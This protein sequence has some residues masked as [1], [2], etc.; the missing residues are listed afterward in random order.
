MDD[1]QETIHQIRA[2]NRFYTVLLGFLNQDYFGS[3]YSVTQTRILFELQQNGQMSASQL[4]DLLHLD[5][6][7]VSRLIRSLEQKALL[8]RRVSPEDGRARILELTPAGQA[9]T[10]RLIELTD[11]KIYE[12][13]KPLNAEAC[14]SLCQAMQT[15]I[16]SLGHPNP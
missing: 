8:T 2:F 7:Y 14:D 3:G 5:K 9:E 4:I 15:I 11:R 13:V 10:A 6:S 12:L 16:G 1:R